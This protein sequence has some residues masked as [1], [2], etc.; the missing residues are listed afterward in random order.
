MRGEAACLSFRYPCTDATTFSG[1]M[2]DA[3]HSC[4]IVRRWLVGALR[5]I[6][7]LAQDFEPHV[8]RAA[9]RER[10]QFVDRLL[11]GEGDRD[12]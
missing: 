2:N 5:D 11:N 1:G 9:A 4:G 12:M 6:S 7:G 3:R 10:G 8:D